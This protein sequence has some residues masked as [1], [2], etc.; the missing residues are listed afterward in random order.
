MDKNF[1]TRFGKDKGM[2]RG[3][4]LLY[5]C[6]VFVLFIIALFSGL[7]AWTFFSWLVGGIYLLLSSM[8]FLVSTVVL[9]CTV[10]AWI[11]SYKDATG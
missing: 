10:R 8:I 11:R 3:K 9:I 7:A 4:S 1:E 2:S 6:S 5:F